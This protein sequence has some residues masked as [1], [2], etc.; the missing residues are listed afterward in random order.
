MKTW[1]VLN[2]SSLFTMC[3]D[4]YIWMPIKI[5]FASDALK[6]TS[7]ISDNY[8]WGQSLQIFWSANDPPITLDKTGGCPRAFNDSS[9]LSTKLLKN[10]K[11]SCCSRKFTG[12]PHNLERKDYGTVYAFKS[13]T[14]GHQ[15]KSLK[16]FLHH[17]YIKVNNLERRSIS[18]VV[19]IHMLWTL[20][21]SN[22][23]LLP[24]SQGTPYLKC[25][26]N[27]FGT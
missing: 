13:G 10:S 4:V 22:T 14:P 2:Q 19:F 3:I 25:F 18:E 17:L 9:K 16:T 26:Q 11:A 7:N 23:S 12:S 24:Y 15:D 6:N 1:Q 21:T 20:S 5:Y 8:L 27:P